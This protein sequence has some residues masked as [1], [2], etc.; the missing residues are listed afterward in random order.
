MAQQHIAAAWGIS[1]SKTRDRIV[2]EPAILEIRP[3]RFPFRRTLELLHEKSLRLAVHFHQYRALL[4]LFAFLRRTLL[5]PR[6]RD[7]AFFRDNLHS[8]GELALLH[9]HHE[10]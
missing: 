9:V 6:N 8:L 3:R 2:I 7:P 5:L 10:V 4:I 1:D